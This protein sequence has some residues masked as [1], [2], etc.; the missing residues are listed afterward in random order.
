MGIVPRGFRRLSYGRVAISKQR[1]F[2]MIKFSDKIH[3][4]PVAARLVRMT[5]FSDGTRA[6]TDALDAAAAPRPKAIPLEIS[7]LLARA[8]VKPT[9]GKV[10]VADLDAAF[11]KAGMSTTQRMRAKAQLFEAGLLD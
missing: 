5:T 11:I 8:G 7:A 6:I 9:A 4:S 3:A 10:K 2:K 1:T